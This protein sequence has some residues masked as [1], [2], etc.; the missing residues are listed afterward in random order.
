V[1]VWKVRAV[2]GEGCG[3]SGVWRVREWRVWRVRV[4]EWRVRVRV[5]GVGKVMVMVRV[6]G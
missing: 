4:R 2:E 1:R 6:E 3:G 5:R